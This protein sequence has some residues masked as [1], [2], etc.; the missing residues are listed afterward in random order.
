MGSRFDPDVM[1]QNRIVQLGE[2]LLI[3]Q[4][5]AVR[6]GKRELKPLATDA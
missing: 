2:H 6:L 1:Q 3:T 5:G 4:S